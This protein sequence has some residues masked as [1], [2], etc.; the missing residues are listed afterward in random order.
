MYSVMLLYFLT[1]LIPS[2]V[3]GRVWT[4]NDTCPVEIKATI[5]NGDRCDSPDSNRVLCD[6]SQEPYFGTMVSI[7]DALTHCPNISSLN[8]RVTLLGCSTW[9]DRWNFPLSYNRGEM[10]PA[11]KKLR[12]E[13]YDFSSVEDVR[14]PWQAPLM[15]RSDAEA[16]TFGLI[17]W[18]RK[19]YWKPWLRAQVYGYPPA[20]HVKSNLDLWLQAMDWS[21]IEEL[22]MDDCRNS[23][24]IAEKLPP[25]LTSLRRLESADVDFIE[26]LSNNTLS[27]LISVGRHE[28]GDLEHVLERQGASLQRLEFRCDE[29]SC[30]SMRNA[31]KIS[32]LPQLAPNLIHVSINIPRNGS[33]PLDHFRAL[34]ALPKLRSLEVYSQLQSEC[35]RQKPEDYTRQMLD[36]LQEHGRDYC[37]GQERLQQPNLDEDT[38]E[39]L[40]RYMREANTGN[41]IQD[42][43]L[44][45]GDWSRSWDGPLYSPPWMES[46]QAEIV[47]SR[48]NTDE[49]GKSCRMQVSRGYWPP[50]TE[51]WESEG[52]MF[53]DMELDLADYEEV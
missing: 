49:S 11:L 48:S 32:I 33:W 44:R 22:A 14:P 28:A 46:R 26:A 16:W 39:E 53:G 52:W 9:P 4:R 42:L 51:H 47:C 29:L 18:L 36:Y 10:Y 43:T 1:S 31:F 38:A 27:D 50:A 41:H 25:R 40:W 6:R 17:D 15:G 45:I 35:Q 19:G 34:A 30:P 13:G 5:P 3:N 12:L 23:Q 7:H 20:L 37:T 2:L 21:Q 8:L 24:E